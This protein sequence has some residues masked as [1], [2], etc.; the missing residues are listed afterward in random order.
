MV[1][2]QTKI[3]NPMGMHMRPAQL[4]VA[5]ITPFKSNVTIKYGDRTIV[6]KSIM[7]LM[8]A[9]MK[10]GSEIEVICEGPDEQECLD[11]AI[12]LIESGLGE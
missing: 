9:C 5:A 2:K 6:A 11:K 1:S 8:A 12:E 7:N 10:Q 4:F 3:I